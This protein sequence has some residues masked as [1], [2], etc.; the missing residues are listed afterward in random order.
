MA[1]KAAV[2][3]DLLR[4]Y[5]GECICM[6]VRRGVYAKAALEGEGCLVNVIVNSLDDEIISLNTSKLKA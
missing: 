1:R 2:K 4:D 5:Q 3:L 6:M